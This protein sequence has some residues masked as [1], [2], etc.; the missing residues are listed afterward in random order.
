MKT[1]KSKDVKYEE[2]VSELN[3]V[4]EE[5]ERLEFKITSLKSMMARYVET[6][7]NKK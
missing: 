7:R 1:T 4:T 2:I 3:E 6:E 5:Q